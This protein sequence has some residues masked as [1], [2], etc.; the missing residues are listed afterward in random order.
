MTAGRTSI[1]RPSAA[2]FF[3]F[4]DLI[5]WSNNLPELSF[6]ASFIKLL[7][8]SYPKADVLIVE[9]IRDSIKI[10]NSKFNLLFC[11]LMDIVMFMG[12]ALAAHL[13]TT[14]RNNENYHCEPLD[15]RRNLQH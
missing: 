7:L 6:W 14:R 9:H 4:R 13:P 1:M 11:V 10:F 5:R 8:W 3:S 15:W 2:S 12:S